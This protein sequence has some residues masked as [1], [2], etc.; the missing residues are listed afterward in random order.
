MKKV[1]ILTV[2]LVS[3]LASGFAQTALSGTYRYST[4]AAITFTGNNFTGSWNANTP[5]SGTY[6][7]SGSRLTL[8]I[9]GGPRARN[10]WTWTVVDANTLRDQDGDSWRKEGGSQAVV[11]L[12]PPISWNVNNMATWIEAVN[13]IRNGGNNREHI[14]TVTGNI[15][16]PPIINESTFGSVTNILV[17]LGGNGILSPSS[18]GSL[19]QIGSEQTVVVKDLILQGRNDNNRSIVVI[20]RGGIFR[21]EGNASV[22]G[23]TIR[24]SGG[25]VLNNGTFIIQDNASVTGNTVGSSGGGV[26]VWSNATFIMNGGTISGNEANFSGG[27]VYVNN[28][29]FTINSGTISGNATT[30]SYSDNKGGA[31][32]YIANG[33]FTMR[34]GSISNN[35]DGGNGQSNGGGGAY[36][37]GRGIFT[38]HDGII[39]GNITRDMGRGGGIYISSSR[40]EGVGTFI[41]LGGEIFNNT[42]NRDGGGVYSS[43]TFT[44]QGGTISGNIA[45]NGGGVSGSLTM[46]NGT[47][48]GNTART[49]GGGVHASGAFSMQNGYI[50]GN[51]ANEQGGGVYVDDGGYYY[52]GTFTKTGGTI[53]GN[54]GEQNLG[55]ILIKRNGRGNAVYYEKNN[56]WRNASAGPTMNTNTYGFWLNE[57]DV[58]ISPSDDVVNFPSGFTGTWRRDNFNNTLTLTINTLKASDQD[59]IWDL[60]SISGDIYIFILRGSDNWFGNIV[61]RLINNNLEISG[62]NGSWNGTWRKQ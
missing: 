9:T 25:G 32:V 58:V 45:Y 4:N 38:M 2:M 21:M 53:Y 5:I 40:S 33:T 47:I 59:G 17:T 30:G 29:T 61:I 19:L 14:I 16:V 54:D 12:Q 1:L 27:G 52:S 15:S 28:G 34:G 24:S 3:V 56:N 39:S 44:M 20:E 7:V 18:N 46:E 50:S 26:Y 37:G 62:G 35:I 49:N 41:M 51:I 10:T 60:T 43:G 23:N 22:T 55:N 57:T 8:N 36:I 13:G 6:S 48:S 31:G 11:P 42:A